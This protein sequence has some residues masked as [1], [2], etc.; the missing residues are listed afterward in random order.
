MM[1]DYGNHME[2]VD[3][4]RARLHREIQ[5]ASDRAY[6]W[7]EATQELKAVKDVYMELAKRQRP[8][9]DPHRDHAMQRELVQAKFRMLNG[10]DELARI[11]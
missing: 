8:G 5:R 9:S 2:T 3:D 1:D 6:S 7:K 10:I 4:V 11:T